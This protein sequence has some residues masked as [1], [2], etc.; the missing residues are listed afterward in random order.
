MDDRAGECKHMGKCFADMMLDGSFRSSSASC[1]SY[2]GGGGE[3][4]GIHRFSHRFVRGRESA[5]QTRQVQ[6]EAGSS[7]SPSLLSGH[8]NVGDTVTVSVDT[9]AGVSEPRLLTL[10]RG[11]VLE[12]GPTG[13]V[14][15]VDHEV[16]VDGILKRVGKIRVTGDMAF[17]GIDRNEMFAGMG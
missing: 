8:I 17:L 10:A 2:A 4:E 6:E 7:E 12:L 15:G 11:F 14:V 13:V 1:G 3:G 5:V 16:S 9:I